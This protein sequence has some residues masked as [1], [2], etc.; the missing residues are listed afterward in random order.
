MLRDE[1]RMHQ[2]EIEIGE[3]QTD[4]SLA[5]RQ[6]DTAIDWSLAKDKSTERWE[7]ACG[8]SRPFCLFLLILGNIFGIASINSPDH[9]FQAISLSFL[10]ASALCL[11]LPHPVKVGIPD[12]DYLLRT[13]AKEHHIEPDLFAHMVMQT[14][15]SSRDKHL[16]QNAKFEA[17]AWIRQHRPKWTDQMK[18]AQ[19]MRC[20]YAFQ[21]DT[22]FER[23]GFKAWANSRSVKGMW[24]VTDWIK[25]GSLGYGYSMPG[26]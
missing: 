21:G 15:F 8:L 13:K 17:K 22:T 19:T 25:T 2:T 3:I 23:I 10:V 4:I 12:L 11:C 7:W 24:S 26:T 16:V 6:N 5:A 18:T 14:V 20:V 1:L 9:H